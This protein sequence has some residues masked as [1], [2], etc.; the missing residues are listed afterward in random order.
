MSVSS[1]RERSRSPVRQQQ[2]QPLDR[3]VEFADVSAPRPHAVER[4]PAT[5]AS[6]AGSAVI[7]YRSLDVKN[8]SLKVSRDAKGNPRISLYGPTFNFHPLGDESGAAEPW[9]EMP[10][11]V[12]TEREGQPV[13]RFKFNFR[14]SERQAN[15]VET[16]ADAWAIDALTHVSAEWNGK[17]LK[18]D[19]V[20]SMYR[21]CLRREEGREPLMSMVYS[22]KGLERFRSVVY[23]FDAL[24]DGTW[25]KEHRKGISGDPALIELMGEHKFCKAK[26]RMEARFSGFA[27]VNKIIYPRWEMAKVYM[28]A[29]HAS[30]MADKMAPSAEDVALM[31]DVA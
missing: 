30:G 1:Q 10:F 5:A 22:T 2:Q 27:V 20:Q 12:A 3:P 25:S 18:R 31:F 6:S 11:P 14:V 24:E 4:L 17:V 28:K 21:S 26:L 13:D 8:W 15:W 29:P 19:Q 16:V 23:Y 9:S 7:S